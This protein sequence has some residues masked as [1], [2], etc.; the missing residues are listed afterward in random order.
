MNTSKHFKQE[1]KSQ[2][3]NPKA[4]SWVPRIQI[5][6]GVKMDLQEFFSFQLE[7]N[8]VGWNVSDVTEY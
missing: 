6:L 4:E 1:T 5:F 2:V 7:K 3:M 8:V